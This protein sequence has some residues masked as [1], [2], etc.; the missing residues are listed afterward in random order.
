MQT[1]SGD[2]KPL[3]LHAAES[4]ALWQKAL[5][6]RRET[7]AL[8]SCSAKFIDREIAR[9][10]LAAVKHGRNVKI[11]ADELA[12]YIRDLPSYEPAV[13]A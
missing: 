4:H 11:T 8:L 3:T 12:R 1:R 9:G 6:S 7:A 10:N 13:S 2:C 5:W